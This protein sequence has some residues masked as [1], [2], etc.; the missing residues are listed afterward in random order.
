MMTAVGTGKRPVHSARAFTEQLRHPGH[1]VI[2]RWP[3]ETGP[4]S[5]PVRARQ[6]AARGRRFLQTML[7]V[8]RSQIARVMPPPAARRGRSPGRRPGR[9]PGRWHSAAPAAAGLVAVLAV[10]GSAGQP[11]LQPLL[12]GG[13]TASGRAAGGV[14]GSAPRGVSD[15]I[16]VLPARTHGPVPPRPPSA[17]QLHWLAAGQVPG[18]TPAQHAM[19]A[20]ALL[21]LR[22][23][24]RPDGAVPAAWYPGWKYAWPRDSSWVAAALAATGHDAA[25]LAVLRF[26]ARVQPPSGI[27][28]ARYELS[29]AG[30]VR[31]GRPD[32][33]DADGWFPWAA[34]FWCVTQPHGAGGRLTAAEGRELA[35]LWPAVR[36]A[37]ART[38]SLLGDHGLTPSMDYWEDR[39][40]SSSVTL[41]TA[42]PLLTG[43]RAA[44]RVATALGQT[45]DARRWAAAASRLGHSIQ[46][47]FGRTGYQRTPAASSGAD[48]AVTF[49]GPPFAAASP[50]VRQAVAVTTRRLT[51]ANGGIVPGT[52]WPG[53]PDEAWT[54]ETGFF[55]LYDA[56]SGDRPAAARWLGW[57]AGHRTVYGSLPEQ[58]NADG[59]PASVA[60]L[61]WTDAIALLAM[62]AEQHPLP[63]P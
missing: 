58:V 28:A 27:W 12:T 48:A 33:L 9:W 29:G 8:T 49:L 39:V 61:A 30:P 6:Q 25:A 36:R 7:F 18:S 62:T 1:Q 54:P 51:L 32:E 42:A 22:L 46:V 16:S 19:A 17:A 60:P 23:L 57:L 15:G 47:R 37:A 44:A 10:S 38:T 2:T 3:A 43:L 41:G 5:G 35:G 4:A 50:G 14:P 34:W 59:Q 53:D 40:S 20:R 55:A 13:I 56:A 24:I 21:D 11:Y 31:D 45:A 26:I 63:T 52:A